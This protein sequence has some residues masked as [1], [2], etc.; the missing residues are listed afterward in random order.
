MDV[1]AEEA[2]CAR[3]VGVVVVV[4]CVCVCV[5]VCMCTCAQE[6]FYAMCICMSVCSYVFIIDRRII[7]TYMHRQIDRSTYIDIHTYEF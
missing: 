3:A 4:V 7:V 1:E 6:Y 2:L 5:C